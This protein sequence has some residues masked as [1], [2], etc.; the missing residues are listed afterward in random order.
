VID[1]ELDSVF[2]SFSLVHSP[3]PQKMVKKG[4]V[5]KRATGGSSNTKGSHKQKLRTG[6][7]TRHLDQVRGAERVQGAKK[8]KNQLWRRRSVFSHANYLSSTP[9][10]PSSSHRSGTTSGRL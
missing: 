2:F 6:F 7:E 3:L 5:G 9:P 8:R 1:E 10:H 4:G